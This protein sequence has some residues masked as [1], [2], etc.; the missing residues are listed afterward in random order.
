MKQ[1]KVTVITA[2]YN[3][4]KYLDDCFFY[5]LNQSYDNIEYIIVDDGSTD[6]SASIMKQYIDKFRN[7]GYE[8]KI[9]EKENGGAASAINVALKKTTG[10]YL[11]LFDVDDVLMKDSV[12]EKAEYLDR[13]TEYGIVRS[14]GYYVKSKN[15]RQNSYLFVTKKHEKENQY[16]FEDILYG[17]TNNWSGSFMVRCSALF[18]S[19]KNQSIYISPWGQNMQI[20]LPVSYKY[21]AGFI[22]KPLMRYVEHGKS[23]SRDSSPE[24]QLQLLNGYMENRIEIIKSMQINKDVKDTYIQRIQQYYLH[25]RLRYALEKGMI[26]LLEKEYQALH[27][28]QDISFEDRFYYFLGHHPVI[29]M[30]YQKC[31]ILLKISWCIFHKIEGKVLRHD[32]LC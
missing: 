30:L 13:H 6:R 19:I 22:D 26:S 5:I 25:V 10:E 29:G 16:I 21:M 28:S 9:I 31:R 3:G 15:L 1:T 17:K 12:K 32:K 11:T 27:E 8:Y 7:R 4:E 18:D 23:V 2:C 14:N 24:R 20:L